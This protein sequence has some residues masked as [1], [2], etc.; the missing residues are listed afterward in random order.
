M[1]LIESAFGGFF[2]F[3]ESHSLNFISSR[4]LIIF[5]ASSLLVIK[6]S[7]NKIVP[8]ET[9]STGGCTISISP[10]VME[11]ST[12]IANVPI[13]SE[14]GGGGGIC[15]FKMVYLK[16]CKFIFSTLKN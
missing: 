1:Q 13:I 12:I 8:F 11:E 7:R 15:G 4:S 2:S 9:S 16:I 14:G 3:A 10:W 6:V 5:L